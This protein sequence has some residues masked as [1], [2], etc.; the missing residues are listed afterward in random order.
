MT[1]HSNASLIY[2]RSSK[3]IFLFL[4]EKDGFR[5]SIKER[6]NFLNHEINMQDTSLHLKFHTP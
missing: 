2:D 4:A 1:I 6:F 3:P 5:S